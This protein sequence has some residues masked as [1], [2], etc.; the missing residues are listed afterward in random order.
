MGRW[1][2]CPPG[3]DMGNLRQMRP[4]WSTHRC[5]ARRSPWL[6]GSKLAGC[7]GSVALRWTSL[8][9]EALEAVPVCS[10][11]VA[12][13]WTL[14][15]AQKSLVRLPP[16]PGIT[17]W[18]GPQ[19]GW[20]GWKG[21]RNGWTWLEDATEESALAHKQR[22]GTRTL[23]GGGKMLQREILWLGIPYCTHFRR[24]TAADLVMGA[25][26]KSLEFLDL[27]PWRSV[28][29]AGNSTARQSV[30]LPA[31]EEKVAPR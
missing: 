7:P 8:F 5:S 23:R 4:G 25:V 15:L 30:R 18:A 12:E 28:G 2:D 14:F 16:G 27:L 31:K 21:S 3:F 17:R 11:L 24:A 6:S 13:T 9:F 19:V 10:L 1:Q 20:G 29:R 26:A 22:G